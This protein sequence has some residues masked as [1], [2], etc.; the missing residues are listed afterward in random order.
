[1]A[2]SKDN[3]QE[4]VKVISLEDTEEE[5]Q[6]EL[7]QSSRPAGDEKKMK[8]VVT[9]VPSVDEDHIVSSSFSYYFIAFVVFGICF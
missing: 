1:M 5:T 4:T 2:S 3:V 8:K 7:G 6:L 9:G